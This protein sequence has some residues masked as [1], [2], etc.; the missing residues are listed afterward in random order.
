MA[1]LPAFHPGA[2]KRGPPY[3]RS[4][5]IAIASFSWAKVP[6][7]RPHD[8]PGSDTLKTGRRSRNQKWAECTIRPQL[9]TIRERLLPE[10]LSGCLLIRKTGNEPAKPEQFRAGKS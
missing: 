3:S 1:A 10:R 8:G 4:L 6:C 5:Q 7:R 9:V 2:V